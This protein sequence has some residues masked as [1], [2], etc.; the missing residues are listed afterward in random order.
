MLTVNDVKYDPRFRRGQ[1]VKLAPQL[2]YRGKDN[3][4]YH[5]KKAVIGQVFPWVVLVRLKNGR[6]LT[7]NKNDFFGLNKKA[8]FVEDKPWDYK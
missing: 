7:I 4:D 6:K 3:L 2:I 1:V 5:G 8:V